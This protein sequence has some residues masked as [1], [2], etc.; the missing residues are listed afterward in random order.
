MTEQQKLFEDGAPVDTY[1]LVA[2]W[3][4]NLGHKRRMKKMY[5]RQLKDRI[6][7]KIEGNPVEFGL[8]L[9]LGIL[10]SVASAKLGKKMFLPKTPKPQETAMLW[11]SAGDLDIINKALKEATK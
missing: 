10:L 5:R 9:G 11:L 7:A 4:N 2:M 1:D 8:Q 3:I 6:T